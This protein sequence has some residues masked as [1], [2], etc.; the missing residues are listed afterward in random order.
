MSD[1]PSNKVVLK[2][3]ELDGRKIGYTN[4][5]E[6]LVQ[7]G[8][9]KSSYKTKYRFIGNLH[10]AVLYYK[11]LNVGYGYKKRLLMQTSSK[12][13]LARQFS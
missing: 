7:L 10:Q 1:L 13:V 12:P 11:A 4:Q 3:V 8:R 5:T 9:Y 6:F 2:E